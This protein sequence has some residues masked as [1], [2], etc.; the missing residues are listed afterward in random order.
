M[1]QHYPIGTMP[2]PPQLHNVN[3]ISQEATAALI[4]EMG[5]AHPKGF[6]LK[7]LLN[8]ELPNTPSDM[9]QYANTGVVHQVMKRIII[10]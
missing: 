4:D 9:P 6:I 10:N 5:D 1:Q 8:K 2:Y 3:I 7:S